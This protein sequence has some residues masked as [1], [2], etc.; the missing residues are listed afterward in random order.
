MEGNRHF[1]ER[2][3]ERVET[4]A[5]GSLAAASV[6]YSGCWTADLPGRRWRTHSVCRDHPVLIGISESS[7]KHLGALTAP[8]LIRVARS[9]GWL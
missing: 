5:C 4:L 7:A 1:R 6:R 3:R 2:E 9:R 8:H